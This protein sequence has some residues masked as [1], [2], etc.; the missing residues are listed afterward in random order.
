MPAYEFWCQKC[1]KSFEMFISIAE[2]ERQRKTGVHCPDC[3]G[4]EVE[5]RIS[6]FQVKTSKKS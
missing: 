6:A 1:A 3:G 2:Y 5:Q 4:T